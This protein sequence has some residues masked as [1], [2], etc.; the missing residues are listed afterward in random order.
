MEIPG[1]ECQGLQTQVENY[2]D[3]IDSINSI[4]LRWSRDGHI[5]FLNKY[6][7]RFFGYAEQEIIGRHVIGTI[8]P[9]TET[10]GR[11]LRPLMDQILKDPAAFEQNVNENIRKNGERVWISWSNKLV[12]DPLGQVLEVL[13]VGQD[14]T[15]RREAEVRL[16]MLSKY[17]NDFIILLDDQFRFLETNER[18][19]EYYGYT[20]A[21]M[22]GMHATVLRAPET[23]ANFQAQVGQ[24]VKQG[25]AL[26]ETVHRRKDG[27]TFPVEI[28]LRA[29]D[30]GGKR[31]Y[32]AV[33]RDISE[34]KRVEAKELEL[35]KARELGR[36]K[37]L[38]I[39]SMSHE[40]RTP[41]NSIIG[42]TGIMLQ[43]LAGELNGEQKK[44][45][46]MV[47][48]SAGHLLALIN[49]VIDV[50]KIEA[51]KVQLAIEPFDLAAALRSVRDFFGTALAERGHKLTLDLPE[52]LM[53]RSDE[54]RVRQI[55]MNLVGNAIKFT[56]R[57]EIMVRA[58]Q[59]GTEVSVAVSDTGYGIRHE[60]LPKL[61]RQFSRIHA[62]GQPLQ[63]G[64]G[65][66]LYLSQKLAGMLGGE[67]EVKSEPGKGSTFTFKVPVEYR[68]GAK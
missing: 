27:T 51:E 55:V 20:R 37:S 44:Q 25:Q 11:D 1:K 53:V 5:T 23:K 10:G 41:L 24:A 34:R 40:L 66:G 19:Q 57:G 4:V 65:L 52:Q 8:V 36:L 32:Q 47:K 59:S 17:A 6:G 48:E 31:L 13:S 26:Y 2:R 14:I 46:G 43:G 30:T 56:D 29:I 64:T 39:A 42:F 3:L 7:Q 12:L 54:R 33:I 21:E 61:F 22:L 15:A 50:S 28:N 67:I 38:F 16:N 63:E 18:C 60:D 58:A 35:R 62:E 68:G 9:E 49:D 45:L